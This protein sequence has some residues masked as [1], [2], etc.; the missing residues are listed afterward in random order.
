MTDTTTDQSDREQELMD[1]VLDSFEGRTER[2]TQ[3]PDADFDSASA[4]FRSG[5]A[6][7]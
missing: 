2:T 6:A 1:R 5:N 4:R 7:H 3:V